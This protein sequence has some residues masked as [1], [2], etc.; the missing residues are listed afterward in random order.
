MGPSLSGFAGRQ[1]TFAYMLAAA[2]FLLTIATRFPLGVFKSVNFAVHGAIEL[3]LAVLL[4]VLPWIAG[5]SR[6]VLSRNFYIAIA[7]LMIAVWALTDFRG[8]RT[9]VAK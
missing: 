2:L 5:F 4:L 6:G 9:R 8:V 3:M 7:V 1:A